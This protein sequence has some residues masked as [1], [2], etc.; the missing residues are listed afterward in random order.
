MTTGEVIALIKALGGS[1]GGGALVFPTFT[2]T[3]QDTCSCDMTYS[4]IRTAVVNGSCIMSRLVDDDDYRFYP[5]TG[6]Y[7]DAVVF[8]FTEPQIGAYTVCYSIVCTEDGFGFQTVQFL[9]TTPIA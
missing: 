5:L 7:S 1:G 9:P 2:R 6:Y 4:Q 8:A 3:G